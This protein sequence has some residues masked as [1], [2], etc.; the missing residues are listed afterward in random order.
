LLREE[1]LA[2]G[3]HV[4]LALRALAC[5]RVESLLP[6]LGRETRGPFVVA[7][8]DRAVEDLDGHLEI[9]DSR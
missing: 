8:S 1:E 4:V 5:G 2:V 7:A 6:E 3:N 9:L